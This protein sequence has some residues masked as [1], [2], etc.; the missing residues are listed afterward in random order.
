M[1]IQSTIFNS[2]SVNKIHI[3]HILHFYKNVIN[4][5]MAHV[6]W[7]YA[8]SCIFKIYWLGIFIKNH[9]ERHTA[10]HKLSAIYMKKIM[11]GLAKS[12]VSSPI[13]KARRRRAFGFGSEEERKDSSTKM[14]SSRGREKRKGV[15][16][17]LWLR[18]WAWPEVLNFRCSLPVLENWRLWENGLAQN[19]VRPLLWNPIIWRIVLDTCHHYQRHYWEFGVFCVTS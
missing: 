4:L 17:N 2:N 13:R 18:R 9:F 1:R 3:F 19:K 14:A 12:S 10:V 7:S 16:S 5:M 8:L 11:I 15:I 6:V